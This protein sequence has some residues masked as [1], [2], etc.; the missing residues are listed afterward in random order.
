MRVEAKELAGNPAP[1]EEVVPTRY[2]DKP[3]R[4]FLLH[5]EDFDW[6]CSQ[7]I[8]PRFTERDIDTGAQPGP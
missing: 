6:N 2:R 3:E 8:A 7:H 1:T 4:V 5:V